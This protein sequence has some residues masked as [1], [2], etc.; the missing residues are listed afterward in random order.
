MSVSQIETL[1]LTKC[2]CLAAGCNVTGSLSKFSALQ[3]KTINNAG[4]LRFT[5]GAQKVKLRGLCLR[6]C[7]C[8]AAASLMST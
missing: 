3:D 7:G 8:V 5:T 6:L 2:F 4:A 1:S